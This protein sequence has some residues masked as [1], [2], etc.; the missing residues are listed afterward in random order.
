MESLSFLLPLK[1]QR[2]EHTNDIC[3]YLGCSHLMLSVFC[4]VCILNLSHSNIG[5]VFAVGNV[6]SMRRQELTINNSSS[7][8]FAM[9]IYIYAWQSSQVMGGLQIPHS[10]ARVSAHLRDAVGAPV[11]ITVCSAENKGFFFVNHL[12]DND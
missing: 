4:E 6:N 2:L 9:F 10:S 8:T 3:H 11:C 7:D 5:N 1:L 12:Q